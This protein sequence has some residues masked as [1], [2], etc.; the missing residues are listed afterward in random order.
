[1]VYRSGSK[2]QSIFSG[3]FLWL[4]FG[5]VATSMLDVSIAHMILV[6]VKDRKR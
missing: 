5:P 2:L 3:Y 6:G 4:R 1:M